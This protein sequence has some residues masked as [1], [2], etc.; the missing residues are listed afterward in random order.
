MGKVVRKLEENNGSFRLA[1]SRAMAKVLDVRANDQIT[2]EWTDGVIGSLFNAQIVI[3]KYDP[4]RDS[5]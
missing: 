1:F 4:R 5:E 3:R 2:I